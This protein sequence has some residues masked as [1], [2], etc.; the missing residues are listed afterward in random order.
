LMCAAV[1]C[2]RPRMVQGQQGA[3]NFI[4]RQP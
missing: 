2:I 1:F 3:I 4:F